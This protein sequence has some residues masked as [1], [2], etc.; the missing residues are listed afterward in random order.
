[1][2]GDTIKG[3]SNHRGGGNLEEGSVMKMFENMVL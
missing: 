3:D 2:I 1:V